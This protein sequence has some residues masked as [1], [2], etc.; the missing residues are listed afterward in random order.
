LLNRFDGRDKASASGGNGLVRERFRPAATGLRPIVAAPEV[1][2]EERTRRRPRIA[3]VAREA[4]VSKTAVSFAFNRPSRLAP[5]T[6]IR[7][8]TVAESL[9]YRPHPVARM[10]TQRSTRTIGL[11]TP[12]TLSVIFSNPFFGAF[13]EGVA[14]AAEDEGYSL[15]VISPLNGSLTRAVD[16]AMVDGVV[17][18]G[19]SAQHPEV[20]QLRAAGLP[21]VM[22]DSSALPDLP[23][24]E[25][26]DEGGAYA[27]AQHLIGL[28][29]RDLLIVG[30]ET[31]PGTPPEPAGVGGRRMRGYRRAIVEH[32]IELR[33]DAVVVAPSTIEGGMAALR[34][35][36]ED[37]LRPTGVLVMSD[38]MAIGVLRAARELGVDVPGDLSVVGF[39]DI[40]ISQHTNPPLTTVH[41][42]IRLK[43]E[44][45]VRSLLARIERQDAV[46]DQQRLAT[47]LIIRGSTGPVARP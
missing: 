28:G 8:R 37:G 13:A 19:V 11:L 5:E 24:V 29:H 4:G 15:Q 7:I 39:D 42:P 46:V 1:P 38:A 43:G 33:E 17:A 9:G 44:A 45:A 21:L 35:A 36:W 10:L 12:Q 25:V 34:G 30:I 6:A 16:R 20:E 47:R 27:A 26:D 31:T 40:D 23:T 3:D 32:G 18:I 14:R 22:V 2:V 41:Q